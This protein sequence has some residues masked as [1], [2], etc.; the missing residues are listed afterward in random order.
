M[1]QVR[2]LS[3]AYASSAAPV[4]QKISFSMRKGEVL[5]LAGKSGS[6]KSTLLRLIRGELDANVG[7]VLYKGEKVR[8]P[9]LELIP[10]HPKMRMIAQQFKLMPDHTVRENILHQLLAF[11]SDFKKEKTDQLLD[12][13]GLSL[14]QHR[15]PHELSGGQQQLLAICRAL[16]EEPELLLLDEPFAHLDANTKSEIHGYLLNLLKILDFSMIV[17]SHDAHDLL[18]ISDRILVMKDGKLIQSGSPE[19][20]FFRPETAYT[21]GLFGACNEIVVDKTR[22]FI[23]PGQIK[24]VSSSKAKFS[25]KLREIRFFGEYYELTVTNGRKKIL[26]H[27]LQNKWEKGDELHLSW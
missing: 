12:L 8:G 22:T 15:K 5:G 27:V 3:F 4:L 25:G 13:T 9:S 20:I 19:A 1:L 7:E 10:G 18:E 24:L 16:A 14:H 6:G 26:V 21:A 2:S 17:V 11:R 23:R